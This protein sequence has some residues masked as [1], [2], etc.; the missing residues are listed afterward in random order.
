MKTQMKK[1]GDTLVVI[2]N[3]KLN[4]E[5]ALPLREDLGRLIRQASTDSAPKKIIFNLEQLDFVGSSGI[6]SFVQTLRDFNDSA[7]VKPRYCHVKSEFQKVIK[8]FD[9]TDGFEFYENEEGAK[10]SFDQ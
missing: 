2:M 10:K 7:P 3:G 6:S 1:V 4:F 5:T 8:A 9:A